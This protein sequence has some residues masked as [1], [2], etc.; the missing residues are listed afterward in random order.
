MLK[1]KMMHSLLLVQSWLATIWTIVNHSYLWNIVSL[2]SIEV[3]QSCVNLAGKAAVWIGT[4]HH[5]SRSQ[6]QL[7]SGVVVL[8]LYCRES[9]SDISSSCQK[10]TDTAAL[11]LYYTALYAGRMRAR[12][13]FH[14]YALMFSSISRR[15]VIKKNHSDV[16][17]RGSFTGYSFS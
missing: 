8:L 7:K 12:I 3:I 1:Q 5:L 10:H 6:L 11:T 13:Q 2:V 4:C 17:G 9:V 16:I 14:Y 15:W